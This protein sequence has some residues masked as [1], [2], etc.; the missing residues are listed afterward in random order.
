MM[1]GTDQRS[2][3][4]GDTFRSRMAQKFQDL[5]STIQRKGRQRLTIMMI[6]H[7]EKKILNLHVNMYTVSLSLAV[8]FVVMVFSIVSLVGKSGEDI[9]F[10]DMG[11][12]NSQFNIQSTRMADE[13][14]PLHEMIQRYTGTIAELYLRLDGEESEV[15]GQGGVAQSILDDEIQ[16]LQTLVEQCKSLGDNCNQKLTEEILRR[17]TYLSRQDNQNLEKALE[18]S[19]RI[20]EELKS[21]EKQNLL[22]NTPSIW[23]VQ[24]YLYSPFGWQMDQLRGKEVFRQGVEIGALPGAEVYATAPGKVTEIVYNDTFGLSLWI[25][26]RY[27]IKTFYAHL[28]RIKVATGDRV[29]K[30]DVIG[31]VGQSGEMPLPMLY[32]EVHVGTVPY[33]PHAFLNHIQD[34]WLIKQKP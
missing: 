7:T 21:R 4:S 8:L 32:Y 20:L 26:H 9:E 28:D 5:L 27:G 13:M 3:S 19:T 14:I 31:F 25:S 6:P 24:G 2:S 30:G 33:N 29:K 11:L 17:I 18:L 10:Y 22:K 23:P 16:E 12:T 15:L 1:P 34:Q